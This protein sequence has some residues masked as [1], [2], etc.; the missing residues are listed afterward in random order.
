MRIKKLQNMAPPSREAWNANPGPAPATVNTSAIDQSTFDRSEKLQQ[1]DRLRRGKTPYLGLP[2]RLS[3]VWINRWT[4]LLLLILV[5]VLIM[6]AGLN[7]DLGDAKVKALAA[8]TKVEDIGSAMASMPHYLSVGVNSLAAS[9][10]SH[11]IHGMM[12]VLDMILTGVEEIIL[13][14]INMYV[15][16]YACLIAAVVHGG[17]NVSAFVVTKTT[18]AMNDAIHGIASDLGSVVSGIQKGL[19]DTWGTLQDDISK[20]SLGLITIPDEPKLDVSADLNKLNGVTIN[21]DGFV[22]D[23]DNLNK[24]LPTFQDVQNFTRNAISIPFDF[25]KNALN[26]SYGD[27]SFDQSIFPVA[28]KEAL[29]FCSDNSIINDFFQAVYQ[30]AATAKIAFIVVLCVLA[31]LACVPMA[32]WEIRRWRTQNGYKVL[33]AE[34][35]YDDFDLMMMGA[36]PLTS[37]WGLKFA[38]WF[39]G[40]PSHPSYNKRHVLV[41]WCVAYGTSLPAIFVLSLALAGFFSCL[42]QYIILAAIQ[43]EVPALA[44]KVGDFAG[45]VVTTL[46]KASEEWANDANGVILGFNSEINNDVL[47]YVTNATDAVNNTINIFTTDMNK[48]LADV[49]NGTIL[50]DP[51]QDVIYC[52]LGM[53]IDAVQKGLTWVHDNAKV[54]LPLFPNDTFSLGAAESIDGDSDLT[55]FLASPSSVTSDEVTGAVLHVTNALYNN[56][57]Q[58]ALI[59]TG[60]LLVYVVIVL[61]GVVRTLSSLAV[62]KNEG[63]SSTGRDIYTGGGNPGSPRQRQAGSMSEGPFPHANGVDSDGNPF[64]EKSGIKMHD[65]PRRNVTDSTHQGHIRQSSYGETFGDAK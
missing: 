41:R 16:T 32:Y 28:K 50:M 43:K 11:A 46:E 60:L 52:L 21:S 59:S 27:W 57:I 35:K 1:A 54:S 64:T 36:R 30:V 17:L 4:V 23:I 26:E 65:L 56:L 24:E 53:K 10:I 7:E 49:F 58:E 39:A 34:N 20:A 61:I 3:Q 55:S 8:C 51:I 9:G 42:C 19:D 38:G 44:D 2:A 45:E 12:T 37:K 25:V 63:Y 18:D 5:R 33:F 14:V 48:A 47:G 29:S 31:I 6:L 40:K 22:S 15:S 13:F 62:D